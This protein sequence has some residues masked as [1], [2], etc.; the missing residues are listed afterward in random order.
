LSDIKSKIISKLSKIEKNEN[1]KILYAC[2]SGSRAWGFSSP[3]SDYD[4]RFIYINNLEWYLSIKKMK[5]TIDLPIDENELDISGWDLK[6]TFTL[7][8][9]SNAV[10]WEWLQSPIIY[11]EEKDFKKDLL[12]TANKYY[13]LKSSCFHYL[14]IA[15]NTIQKIIVDDKII[16]KKYFYILRPLLSANWIINNKTIPPMNLFEL[17]KGLEISDNIN[18]EIDQLLKIKESSNEKDK[19]KRIKIIDDFIFEHLEKY[20]SLSDNLSTANEKLD[21]IDNYFRKLVMS[22]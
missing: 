12:K 4:I 15:R 17:I 21:N 20:I 9:K 11:I 19:I 5:D 3:D 8:S 1:I 13:S 16:I 18:Y 10:I 2:E 6:K 7:I 14:A 22:V